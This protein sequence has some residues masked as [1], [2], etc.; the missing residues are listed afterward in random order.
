MR[1]CITIRWI[2]MF[3]VLCGL[4]FKKDAVCFIQFAIIF[5]GSEYTMVSYRN[6][7]LRSVM[8]HLT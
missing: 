5:V 4:A 7:Y 1:E 8:W 3:Q 6:K 2:A